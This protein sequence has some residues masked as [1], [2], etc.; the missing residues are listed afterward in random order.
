MGEVTILP[1][2]KY[3]FKLSVTLNGILP[4]QENSFEHRGVRRGSP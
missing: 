1:L 4:K 3:K 2:V